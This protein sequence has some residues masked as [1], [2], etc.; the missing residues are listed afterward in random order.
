MN[1]PFTVF[2][3]ETI[4]IRLSIPPSTLLRTNNIPNL[5]GKRN[6]RPIEWADDLGWTSPPKS[7]YISPFSYHSTLLFVV[8]ITKFKQLSPISFISLTPLADIYQL[9]TSSGPWLNALHVTK[10]NAEH[11]QYSPTRPLSS[12][13]PHFLTLMPSSNLFCDFPRHYVEPL[14]YSSPFSHPSMI[15][16]SDLF[17]NL[18][19][20]FHWIKLCYVNQTT[21]LACLPQPTNSLHRCYLRKHIGRLFAPQDND[22][23]PAYFFDWLSREGLQHSLFQLFLVSVLLIPPS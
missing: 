3:L 6:S 7:P 12:N 21:A 16:C 4:L 20:F 10:T 5:R 19:K 9:S 15:W 18:G 1:N 11:F 8:F 14:M 2:I 23:L 17:L 13:F 22:W